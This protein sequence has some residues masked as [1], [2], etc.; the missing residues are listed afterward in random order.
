[1]ATGCERGNDGQAHESIS[2]SVSDPVARTNTN[3][4][5]GNEDLQKVAQVYHQPEPL[6]AVKRQPPS[7]EEL[8]RQQA[9]RAIQAARQKQNKFE[10]LGVKQINGITAHGTRTTQTVLAGE[11]GNDQPLVVVR[12]MWRSSD[13]DLLLYAMTDDPRRGRTAMEFEELNQGEPD[14]ALF[15]PPAG[16]TVQERSADGAIIQR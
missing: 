7:A 14:P 4:A 10:D 13:F 2:V 9:A 8:A 1:M 11:A 3:W 16:Y 5:V 6:P 15:A 12:E